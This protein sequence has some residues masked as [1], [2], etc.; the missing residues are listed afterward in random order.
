MIEFKDEL[1]KSAYFAEDKF[2]YHP[3]Q[4]VSVTLVKVLN[5]DKGKKSD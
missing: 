2:L 4:K 5:L 3:I 1:L